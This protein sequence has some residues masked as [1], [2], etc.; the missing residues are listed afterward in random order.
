MPWNEP[1]PM[2]RR[3]QFI[4]DYLRADL[5][6]RRCARLRRV[7]QD[8]LQVHRALLER[9]ATGAGRAF[10]PAA[11]PPQRDAAPRVSAVTQ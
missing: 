9:W 5:S 2:H 3:L 1:T 10:P 4:A 11:L 6:M 7:A 8:R